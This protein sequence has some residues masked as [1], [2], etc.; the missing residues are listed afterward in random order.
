MKRPGLVF[1]AAVAVLAI[2][3]FPAVSTSLSSSTMQKTRVFR[4]RTISLLAADGARAAVVTA[5]PI[6]DKV[7]RVSCYRVV[8][9]DVP[10]RKW[11][12]ISTDVCPN[13]SPVNEILGLALAGERVAW[14]SGVGG[15]S[16]DLTVTVRNPGAK[17]SIRVSGLAENSNGAEGYP[18]GSY[19]GNLVGK[20]NLLVYNGWSV[21]SAVPVGG[22]DDLAT[23]NEPA[24]GA[25]EILIYSNQSL[26]EVVGSKSV[27]IARAPDIQ[28]AETSD[29]ARISAQQSL[30]AVWVD[31]GRIA[32]QPQPGGNVT[33]F[34]TKG[35]VLK[36]I[37]VPDG[38]FAGTVLQG[39]QLLTLR[40]GNLELYSVVTGG[41]VKTIPA[42]PLSRLRDLYK[43]VA[44]YLSGRHIHVLRLSDRKQLTLTPPGKGFVD[45]RI[46]A[47]GLYYAYNLAKGVD[48]GRIVFIPLP[49]VLKM[50]R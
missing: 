18:D 27:T 26:L 21:C 19:V 35:A 37:A 16:L 39:A 11:L 36:T 8:T 22:E 13:S 14:L 34:S 1:V 20:G 17:K 49:E 30:A 38:A 31:A 29:I 10:K 6:I 48:N 25:E 43:G 15:N 46:E 47:Q 12:R 40:N 42:A 28:S 45:A 24:P 4:T 9:W 7:G 44:V 33:L 23:C 2:A 5:G 3:I 32:V 41:L 50:L